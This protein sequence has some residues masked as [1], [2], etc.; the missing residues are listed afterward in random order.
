MRSL[1]KELQ[2]ESANHGI[3]TTQWANSIKYVEDP[4]NE[5]LLQS[6]CAGFIQ[7]LQAA[8]KA[9]Q[10]SIME[11]KKLAKTIAKRFHELDN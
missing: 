5:E 9:D 8:K 6:N 11:Q 3:L 7:G 10:E 2:S 1:I 4:I